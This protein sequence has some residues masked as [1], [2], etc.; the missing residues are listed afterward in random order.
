M[1]AM[2]VGDS[3][4]FLSHKRPIPVQYQGCLALLGHSPVPVDDLFCVFGAEVHVLA[5]DRY[6]RDAFFRLGSKG[7]VKRLITST[8]VLLTI[9]V[10]YPDIA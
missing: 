2:G 8:Q 9:N 4:L 1:N 3:F 7:N 6:V 10:D 5:L